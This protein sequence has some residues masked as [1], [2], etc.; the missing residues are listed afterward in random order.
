MRLRDGEFVGRELRRDV[1]AAGGR[2]RRGIPIHDLEI[3]TILADAERDLVIEPDRVDALGV[4]LTE[5]VDNTA[6]SAVLRAAEVEAVEPGDAVFLA[7][8]DAV[9]IVF[10]A[11]REV[12]LHQVGEEVLEQAHHGKGDPVGHEGSSARGDV[13]AVDDG[14]DDRRIGRRT[15]DPQLFERLNEARLGISGRCAGLVALRR[16]IRHRQLLSNSEW[17][18]L[19]FGWLRSVVALLVAALLIGLEESTE[20]DDRATRGELGHRRALHGTGGDDHRRCHSLSVGHLG[21]DGAL[22]DEVIELPVVAAKGPLEL[23][24]RTE[25]VPR[26]SDRLVRLLSILALARVGT[27][28]LG[29]TL[30][31]IE[32]GRLAPGSGH[33]LLREVER[34]RTHIGDVPVFVEAL[35]HAH[36]LA[37]GETQLTCGLLLQRRGAKRGRGATRVWLRVDR[38]HHDRHRRIAQC[39]GESRCS[40]LVESNSIRLAIRRRLELARVVEITAA[41]DAHPVEAGEARLERRR[42]GGCREQ[43]R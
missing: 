12:V 40:L 8:G 39:L 33:R 6:E 2:L 13:P 36:R 11:G 25:S 23:P 37:S 14:R 26:R 42:S 31:A 24:R 9:E 30:G 27:G 34:I 18:E 3:R 19:G 29:N 4:D 20:C 41:G 21:G 10:H 22:P 7:V 15:T 17:W 1:H 28:L 16:D 32:R 5:V 43:R 35:G 38:R